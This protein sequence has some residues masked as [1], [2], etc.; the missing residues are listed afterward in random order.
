MYAHKRF[1]QLPSVHPPH[2]RAIA[3][4]PLTAAVPN[5]ATNFTAA[6]FDLWAFVVVCIRTHHQPCNPFYSRSYYYTTQLL[7]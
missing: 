3:P 2:P 4:S 6:C 5:T 1:L 7:M